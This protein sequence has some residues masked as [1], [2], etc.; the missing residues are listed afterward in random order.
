MEQEEGKLTD[1]LSWIRTF[2]MRI[3]DISAE[4]KLEETAILWFKI[5]PSAKFN[6]RKD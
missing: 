6:T 1:R 5:E 2:E 4:R 3:F